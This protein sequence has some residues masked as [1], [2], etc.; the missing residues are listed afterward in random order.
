MGD[1]ISNLRTMAARRSSTVRTL[2]PTSAAISRVIL[3]STIRSSTC[4]SLA[5]EQG[6]PLGQ[7][8]LV[9]VQVP[10][11]GVGQHGLLDGLLKL[12]L[13]SRLLKKLHGPPLDRTHGRADAGV[14][15]K[16]DQRNRGASGSQAALHVPSI[17]V[18]KPQLGNQAA[19][20]RT[21][22]G[23]KEL[24]P[25][26]EAL[27][28]QVRPA[29]QIADSRSCRHVFVENEHRRPGLHSLVPK[30]KKV[31]EFQWRYNS[32]P[33]LGVGYPLCPIGKGV[34]ESKLDAVP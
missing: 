10:P 8:F 17:H 7:L 11:V 15:R 24:E 12:F 4:S 29:R 9:A 16:E 13:F 26:A 27:R 1:F 6:Q 2:T 3:P 34:L 31:V 33:Y 32:Q 14:S 21:L 23:L 18:G 25:R 5:L 20:P 19:R 22:V 30:M 28:E